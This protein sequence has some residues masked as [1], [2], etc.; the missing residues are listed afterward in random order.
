LWLA[1]AFTGT[2]VDLGDGV[3]RSASWR[4]CY[5]M[6]LDPTTGAP[7]VVSVLGGTQLCE[8]HDIGL[9][10]GG[11][12]V[13]GGMFN[14]PLD[15]GGG[16]LVTPTYPGQFVA[17]FDGSGAHVWSHGFADHASG[18]TSFDDAGNVYVCGGARDTTDIGDGT[19]DV[20]GNYAPFVSSFDASGGLRWATVFPASEGACYSITTSPSG[21]SALVLL[22]S[23]VSRRIVIG[24]TTYPSGETVL[25]GVT[26]AGAD[27]WAHVL[28]NT[29]WA[30]GDRGPGETF[31]L[32]GF[33]DG[34][35]DF[36]GGMRTAIGGGF[37]S[38]VVSYD[39]ASGA[40]RWSEIFGSTGYEVTR[41]IAPNGSGGAWVAGTV[42]GDASPFVAGDFGGR[43]FLLY[44]V[45][46]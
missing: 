21:R 45:V 35:T 29:P 17:A 2:D 20:S 46:R 23:G 43:D 40:H 8:P 38:F 14:G 24:S 41:A 16:A 11:G 7:T 9:R 28:S 42:Q 32:T 22:P 5:V 34:S 3:M 1:S 26:G 44:E 18:R 31:L 19:H 10:A 4:A 27:D 37:D 36:G 25:L 33:V 15:L 30:Y 39:V 6:R 13:I 12:F